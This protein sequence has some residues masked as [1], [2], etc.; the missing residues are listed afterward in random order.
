MFG[1][2]AIYL[3]VAV[4]L[5]SSELRRYVQRIA[6]AAVTTAVVL[7]TIA[8]Y[9]AHIPDG[10]KTW[11]TFRS[12]FDGL[13]LGLS[14]IE[15]LPLAGVAFAMATLLHRLAEVEQPHAAH[16]RSAPADPHVAAIGAAAAALHEWREAWLNPPDLPPKEL[17]K[18]TLTNLYNARPDDL[19]ALHAALD[20]AVAAAYGWEWPLSDEEILTRLL[21]LNAARAGANPAGHAGH[22]A[23]EGEQGGD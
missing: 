5:L 11:A 1:F 18:R 3:A 17:A 23:D 8:D 22:E 19:T 10:L 16:R 4:L 2:E 12:S 15:R 9:Q 7:N 20:T 6:L 14:L 13:A 21:A